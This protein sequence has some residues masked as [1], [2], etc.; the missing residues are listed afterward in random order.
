LDVYNV[1]WDAPSTNAG[2]S[3]PCGGGDIGLNVW[4]E[5]GDLLVYLSRSGAFDENNSFLKLGRIRVKLAPN[6]FDADA[7]FR[8]ELRL[9]DGYVEILGEKE[10]LKV[11]I[12]IWVDVF[13]PVAHIK[14]AASRPLTVHA[15]YESWRLAEYELSD[16]ETDACRTL[17]EG[18]VKA[19]AYP[20]EVNFADDAV[21][22]FHRNRNTLAFDLCVNHEGL[23]A[24]RDRLWNPQEGLT[25]GGKLFG[26]KMVPAGTSEGKYASTEFMAWGLES[27][28]PVREQELQVAMHVAN[29]KT[30]EEWRAGLEEIVRASAASASIARQRTQDWWHQFWDRSHIFVNCDK[31]DSKSPP[32]QIGRNYQLFRYQ[33]GCNAYGRYPTKFNGGLFTY[34]PQFV[35]SE[36]PFRPD[37][38]QWGGGSFTAQNQRLVYWPM[39]KSG[40]GDMMRSQFDFYKRALGNAELRSQVYWGIQGASFTEQMEDFGLPVAYEYGWKHKPPAPP[41]VEDNTFIEYLWE[42]VLEFCQMILD[43]RKYTGADIREY[44]PL[45]ESSLTFFNEYYQMQAKQRTGQPLSEDGKLVLF[46]GSAL[47][48]YKGNVLNS[49]C[50]IAALRVVLQNVI[51]LPDDL[52]PGARRD[53]WQTM[54]DR[55]PD[56]GFRDRHGYRTLAPAWKWDRR[57]NRELPQ[58]Y[59]VYPWGIYGLGRPDLDVAIDTW[60]YGLDVEETGYVSWEQSAIF[61]ARL[62]LID[63]AAAY[64]IKKMQDSGCRYPTFWGPGHDWVPDHNWGGSGMIGMQEMVM[65]VD[66]R[67]IH[68]LPAWPKD[69]DVSFKLHAPYNTTVEAVY[70]NGK[71]ESL[72]ITPENRAQD[73]IY[74]SPRA[75]VPQQPAES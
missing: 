34:D 4:V 48:T 56:I 18:P 33:L 40:D 44:L 69:W 35:D 10:D 71:I 24:V 68:L 3:M 38:R 25:F 30:Q 65:Q 8:Q 27:A 45:I 61:C 43:L 21:L 66:E 64:T 50:T 15:A 7:I 12:E 28:T 29:T 58:L 17:K 63:E 16:P 11:Q 54:M 73:V 22:F 41:G 19:I 67:K 53:Q 32:W 39:L 20:D 6:P 36:K 59:P 37:H 57:Q 46:P 49:T 62:G 75:P 14:V 74:P 1:V 42:T 5:N 23:K 51:A 31:P 55:I 52:V 2:E 72:K 47:E 70:K 60:K 13:Q 9:R 26:E